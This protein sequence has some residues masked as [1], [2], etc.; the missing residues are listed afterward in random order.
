EGFLEPRRP[1][2]VKAQARKRKPEMILR[3]SPLQRYPIA[4]L[5]R[6]ERAMTLD[7]RMQRILF[8]EITALPKKRAG[9]LFQIAD[10]LFLLRSAWHKQR[11][12]IGKMLGGF[13]IAQ[14]GHGE[15]TAPCRRL[16]RI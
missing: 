15:I 5:Q 16:R 11:G 12:R 14:P 2:L 13:A 3:R 1:A 8:A 10:A 6:D 9:L 4:R 7:A